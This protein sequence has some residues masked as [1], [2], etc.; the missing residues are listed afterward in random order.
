MNIVITGAS[1]GIGFET[2]KSLCTD[3][4]H[5][6]I[7]LSRNKDQLEVLRKECLAINAN[8]HVYPI[9]FDLQ[10]R[11]KYSLLYRDVIEVFKSV[12]ILVN[13]AGYLSTTPFD[14][15]TSEEIEKIFDINVYS[16]VRLIQLLK[17]LMGKEGH[18]HIVNI[19]SMG[20][21]QG[22]SKFPGL[23]IYSASK[24]A[25]HTLTECMAEE[26]KEDN[27]AVNCLALGGVN[28]EMLAKAFPSF[29]TGVS[30][31]EMGKYISEFISVKKVLFNGKVLPVSNSTP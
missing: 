12:D 8:C 24:S 10:D 13:N 2:V 22:S 25:L 28:T 29:D 7:A 17:P 6:I 19:G 15:V 20:G 31:E 18:S 3:S 11:E 4:E 9:A 30:A 27:I 23:S 21:Y 5:K 16:V 26:F 14:E 1:Q